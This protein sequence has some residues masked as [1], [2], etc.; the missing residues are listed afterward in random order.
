METIKV[1]KAV[2][3]DGKFRLLEPSMVGLNEGEEVRIT[4]ESELDT[5]DILIL[6]G[7]VYAGLS[8]EGVDEIEHAALG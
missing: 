4:V 8:A 7:K 1:L 6:A 3:E 5:E 2:Y